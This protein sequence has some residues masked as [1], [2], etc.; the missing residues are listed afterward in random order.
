MPY[1]DIKK[2]RLCDNRRHKKNKVKRNKMHLKCYYKNRDALLEKA[3]LRY[4]SIKNNKIKYKA[5]LKRHRHNRLKREYGITQKE[6]IL[7][8][9]KQNNKCAICSIKLT[10]SNWG[11]RPVID[12]CHISSKVRG[13]LCN[14][15]N[16]SLGLMKENKKAIKKMSMYLQPNTQR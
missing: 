1:K 8:L 11:S 7:M 2:Q 5:F 16:V 4:Y 6:Y 3:K 12:H 15:C 13:I 14:N 10:S 9:K